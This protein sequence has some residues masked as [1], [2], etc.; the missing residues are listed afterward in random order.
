MKFKYKFSVNDGPIAINIVLERL[1]LAIDSSVHT[2][3]SVSSM[4]L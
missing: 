1:G 2:G 4:S 3:F